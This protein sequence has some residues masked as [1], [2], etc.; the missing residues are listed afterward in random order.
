MVASLSQVRAGLRTR[1]ETISGLHTYADVP[2]TVTPPAAV[3]FPSQG[4]FLL[5]DTSTGSDDMT[6][7]VRVFTS[8]AAEAGQGNLDDF[9]ARSGDRSVKAAIEADPTL[10]GVS[11][12]AVVFEARAYG[13]DD[14]GGVLLNYADLVVTVGV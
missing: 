3:V 8:T 4:V 10:G 12:Y 5:Y 6:F 9:L 2:G 13:T 7:V 14:Y 11:H 1:L